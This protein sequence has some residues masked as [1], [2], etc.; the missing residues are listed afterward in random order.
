MSE[1]RTGPSY[2]EALLLKKLQKTR[3]SGFTKPE[4]QFF[5]FTAK[6]AIE[7]YEIVLF[8]IPKLTKRWQQ[9]I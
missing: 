8:I 6:C 7:I 4:N 1:G 2:R 5:L 9:W 3:L